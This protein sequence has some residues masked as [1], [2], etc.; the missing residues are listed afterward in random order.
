[1]LSSSSSS[2]SSSRRRLS[3]AA[4]LEPSFDLALEKFRDLTGQTRRLKDD[5]LGYSRLMFS[6]LDAGNRVA[7]GFQTCL[8]AGDDRSLYAELADELVDSERQLIS[9]G[10]R[11]RCQELISAAVASLDQQLLSYSAIESEITRRRQLGDDLEYYLKKVSSLREKRDSQ[12][13]AMK[14]PSHAELEKLDR[15]V[16][17][18]NEMEKMYNRENERLILSIN[19]LWRSRVTEIGPAM[20][21]LVAAQKELARLE[22]Q[23][24]EAIPTEE[25]LPSQANREYMDSS[26]ELIATGAGHSLNL[27]IATELTS[28]T[29]RHAQSQELLKSQPQ[30]QPQPQG[31]LSGSANISQSAA[32]YSPA[33]PNNHITSASSIKPTQLGSTSAAGVG[34]APVPGPPANSVSAA[35]A[36]TPSL[37]NSDADGEMIRSEE[38]LWVGTEQVETERVRLKKF[39]KTE[40]VRLI[41]PIKR[42]KIRLE[43]EIIRQSA[44]LSAAATGAEPPTNGDSS[45]LGS[46]TADSTA[47]HS[48][49]SVPVPF[50]TPK[51]SLTIRP[52]TTDRDSNQTAGDS[53]LSSGSGNLDGNGNPCQ[54]R[55]PSLS[56]SSGAQEYEWV[57]LYEERPVIHKEIVPVERVRLRKETEE[58]TT[59]LSDSLRKEQIDFQHQPV[60]V[61]L[62][63]RYVD[64]ASMAL[65]A[66][67][68]RPVWP[69]AGPAPA[70]ASAIAP[71]V[72][73]R[74]PRTF[75]ESPNQNP[76]QTQSR[77]ASPAV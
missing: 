58:R 4:S 9:Q 16:L 67:E 13:A 62:A 40:L 57:T 25:I 56:Q 49:S 29:N 33:K 53:Q 14:Q 42:E 5:L 71:A 46:H 68:G 43:R 63:P 23:R 52:R 22:A 74:Q 32:S 61:Q 39:V 12:L 75:T 48:D 59:T 11:S 60:P 41:V 76:N 24:L 27:T 73:S 45:G 34:A 21:K 44:V 35:A 19:Q 18:A 66:T 17:K 37:N 54:S 50:L 38:R 26:P 8:G 77:L 20:L 30:S 1:M 55:S 65:P 31:L 47:R 51:P 70:A 7:L 72:P 69:A 15:N 10:A 36:G 3:G 2:S 28:A 64:S 6:L